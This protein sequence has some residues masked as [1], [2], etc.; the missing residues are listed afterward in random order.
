MA[1]AWHEGRGGESITDAAYL[2]RVLGERLVGLLENA[3]LLS[4][5]ASEADLLDGNLSIEDVECYI[6]PST[7]AGVG[8][9]EW[10]R[11]RH[12]LL[13]FGVPCECEL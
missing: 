7:G 4:E 12:A 10:A 1:E 3:G 13:S 9:A 2:A 6:G 8:E 5:P 11:H